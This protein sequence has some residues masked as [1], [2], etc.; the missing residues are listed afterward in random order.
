MN[1]ASLP[2]YKRPAILI[3]AATLVVIFIVTLIGVPHGI[4]YAVTQWVRDNG[5]DQVSVEDV[6]FNPFTG[7]LVI[8]QLHAKRMDNTPLAINELKLDF[9]WHKLLSKQVVVE[10]VSIQGVGLV[11]E[12]D[13]KGQLRVGGIRGGDKQSSTEN[14]ADVPWGFAIDT[15]TLADVGVEYQSPE[16]TS[17][18]QISELEI[19]DLASFLPDQQSSFKLDGKL[20]EAKVD[21]TG[22]F[23]LFDAARGFKGKVI[24]QGI[25]F[26]KFAALLPEAIGKLNGVGKLESTLDIQYQPEGKLTAELGGEISLSAVELVT[27]DVSYKGEALSWTGQSSYHGGAEDPVTITLIGDLRLEQIDLADADTLSIQQDMLTWSGDSTI[28]LPVKESIQVINKGKLAS[29]RLSFFAKDRDTRL[30]Y[31]NLTWDGK[32]NF[33]TTDTA[34]SLVAT[35]EI[36]VDDLRAISPKNNVTLL[37]FDNLNIKDIN[38]QAPQMFSA[39]KTEFSGLTLGKQGIDKDDSN[40][41]EVFSLVHYGKL[42]LDDLQY[43]QDKGVSIHAIQQIDVT[44]TVRKTPEGEWNIIRIVDLIKKIADKPAA[45]GKKETKQDNRTP[46]KLGSIHVKGDSKLIFEDHQVKPKFRQELRFKDASLSNLDTSKPEQASPIVID[47]VFGKHASV[48]VSGV[49]SP[50]AKQLK[51]DLTVQLDGFPLPQ[52]STY[53]TQS[54]GYT[55]DSG[56]LNA[57]IRLKADKGKL[58]GNNELSL[59]QLEVTP[60][61]PKEMKKL[62]SKLDVPLETGLAVLRD[63]NNNIKLNLPIAGD[64]DNFKVD[65]SDIIN[66]AL[67]KAMKQAA[68]TYLSTALFPYG[69]LLTVVE[70]VGEKAMQINLDP[71]SYEPGLIDLD[72]EDKKYLAKVAS[73]LKERPEIHVK[74]CGVSTAQD[75]QSLAEQAAK[76]AEDKA[77]QKEKDRQEQ[78]ISIPDEHLIALATRRAE[79]IEAHLVDTHGTKSNRLISCRARI[80]IKDSETKPRTEL[81][82]R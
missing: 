4:S 9:V 1:T 24:L 35:G 34:K 26:E 43:S 80:E 57:T 45:A 70:V 50:F 62:E 30:L 47:G 59:H 68:K 41:E 60:L 18:L 16:L 6:D 37:M 20:D 53:S 44:Q 73:I 2:L 78:E 19:A 79:M 82:L 81:S 42:V 7:T 65:P 74:L 8:H 40:Q 38:T 12:Q 32:V 28:T 51:G 27:E 77:T 5:N 25:N 17:R 66:Q 69:T 61:S 55:I 56:E 63:K 29:G 72:S 22:K 3:A 39:A 13:D 75:R 64:V 46:I 71:I 31:E 54:L 52:L 15:L 76:L 14:N 58:D 36:A 11:I 49:V 33:N 21:I 10:A 67:S 48:D 23:K